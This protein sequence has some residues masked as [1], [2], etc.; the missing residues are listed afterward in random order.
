MAT[1]KDVALKA[2]VSVTTAS[3]SL[4]N[5]GR[6]SEETKTRVIKAAEK[7]GYS[8]SLSARGLK[9][10]NPKAIGIFVDGVSGPVY[11]TIIEAAQER[12]KS[13]GWGLIVGTLNSPGQ[14]LAESMVRESLLAGS[15]ILNGGL[16]ADRFKKS[17]LEKAPMV[18]LDA[19]PEFLSSLPLNQS[20]CRIQIDNETGM[21]LI[22]NEICR[23]NH[24]NILYLEGPSS[25]H[26]SS[27]RKAEFSRLCISEKL[28]VCFLECNFGTVE[29]YK[30][31]KQLLTGG[32]H[33]D[34][35][36][37]SN[38]EMAIGAM[39]ALKEHGYE[40]PDDIIITGFDD[41]E[42]A[43]WVNP[44]LTTVKVDYH[45]L[46]RLIGGEILNLITG[47]KS[48]HKNIVF[49]VSLVKRETT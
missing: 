40:I 44:A 41:I 31:I 33:Y 45:E 2:G 3:Y 43:Q 35:V 23:L 1:I 9:G 30:N 49:P 21:Q 7:L 24:R 22:F 28:Q 6:I 27:D 11:G 8:P 20:C 25:S 29:A 5:Q 39:K 15:V 4:N 32:F 38:D 37:A 19:E 16:A 14:E 34:C 42:T 26:D 47:G 13:E 18:I 46:G 48:V 36:T 17:L 10:V 12:I